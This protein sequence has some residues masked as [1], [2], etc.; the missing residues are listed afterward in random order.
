MMRILRDHYDSGT[1]FTP[2]RDPADGKC[3]S[4][5]MHADPVGTTAASVVAHIR[6]TYPFITYWAS[7][8]NP[9]CG[10]FLPLYLQAEIPSALAVAGPEFSEDSIWWLFKR[11]DE[12]VAVD[13]QARTPAVQ[14]VWMGLEREFMAQAEEKE[15]EAANLHQQGKKDEASAVL[16]N[17]MAGN[18]Q[19]ILP[20]LKMLMADI[21]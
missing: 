15:A 17:F 12:C 4:I 21:S 13:Y 3:Y 5:C 18:L 11:L 9:C 10:V 1:V 14:R 16:R 2:G 19:K 6:K 20:R 7:L 8:G